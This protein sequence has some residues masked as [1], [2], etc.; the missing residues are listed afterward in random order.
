MALVRILE[1]FRLLKDSGALCIDGE[2]E[3]FES[4]TAQATTVEAFADKDGDVSLGD[5]ISLG[6]LGYP[7]NGGNFTEVWVPDD[8]SIDLRFTGTGVTSRLY[9]YY[10]VAETTTAEETDSSVAVKNLLANGDFRTSA[11]A[12]SFSNIS[13]SNA[14]AE[15]APGWSVAQNNSAANA[16]SFQTSAATGA[17]LALRVGRAAAS[18]STDKIRLLARVPTEEVYRCRGQTIT[19][20]FS[21]QA[22]ADFSPSGVAALVATGTAEGESLAL[23]EAGGWT[24]QASLIAVTQAIT[25]SVQR[26]QFSGAVPTNAKEIGVSLG[27]LGVGTAGAADHC[28]ISDVQIEIGAAASAFEALP[29]HLELLRS[30]AMLAAGMLWGMTLSNN[31]SD[32]TNDIDFAAG[33]CVDSTNSVFIRCAA[34]TKR[35]DA[36]FTAGNNGGGLDTGSP[37]NVTYHCFAIRKDA[38]GSGDFL[39]SASA[40]AP[41]MPSGYTYFR[42]IG[43]ILR[44]S[45]A[46]VAFS[47]DGDEFLRAMK[48]DVSAANPGTSAVSRTLSVPTGIKVRAIMSVGLANGTPA[49]VTGL[50][51]SLDVADSAPGVGTANFGNN[52]VTGLTTMGQV[53]CRTNTSGQVRSRL[54]A[55]DASVTLSIGTHGWIDARGR[56]AA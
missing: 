21:V 14:L 53:V 47:Q 35:L 15:V 20:S 33:V 8:V 1:D 7:V 31:A 39:F 10:R 49:N 54:S 6:S 38:D 17:R 32:A 44:E 3:I 52:P 56:L 51:S 55:S 45:A 42:R 50:I 40:T 27:F 25:T 2:V 19:L 41:T 36:T 37:S 9:E 12:A 29:R 22:G 13:G 11:G 18:T 5:T 30:S 48:N 24:G 28:D 23:I 46:I 26:F 4:G 34:L 43:S 16:I